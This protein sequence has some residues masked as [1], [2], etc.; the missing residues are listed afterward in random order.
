MAELILEEEQQEKKGFSAWFRGLFKKNDQV[1]E[2]EAP[3]YKR[4]LLDGRIEKY[5]DQN[6]NAYIQEYGI[7]TS[8]DLEGYEVRYGQLTGRI[9]SMKEYQL[10]AE[11]RISGMEREID[12]IGKMARPKK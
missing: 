5:L 7:L 8:L 11:A 4:K 12:E 2:P 10:N 9:S 3:T 6:M 1:E